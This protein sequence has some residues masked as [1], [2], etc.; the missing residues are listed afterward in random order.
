MIKVASD[1]GVTDE[2]RVRKGRNPAVAAGRG[3]RRSPDGLWEP[4][5][6]GPRVGRSYRKSKRR[7]VRRKKPKSLFQLLFSN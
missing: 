4:W 7:R 1:H 5:A 3:Y 2:F 6:Q